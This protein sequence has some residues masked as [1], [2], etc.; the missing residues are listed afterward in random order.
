L[1]YI[2]FQQTQSLV[3][4]IRLTGSLDNRRFTVYGF[5]TRSWDQL[6]SLQ[7]RAERPEFD[8]RDGQWIFLYS[9]ASRPAF[10]PTQLPI[11]W[12]P[13]RLFPGVKLTTHLHLVTKSIMKSEGRCDETSCALNNTQLQSRDVHIYNS[14]SSQRCNVK[15]KLSL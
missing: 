15:L 4:M 1:S 7:R 13:V 11:Q 8:F 6:Q 3:A 9:T 2:L 14:S 5:Y 12:V 10:G